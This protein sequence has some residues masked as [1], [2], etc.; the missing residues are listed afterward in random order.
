MEFIKVYKYQFSWFI[1]SMYFKIQIS[2][3]NICTVQICNIQ[4]SMLV[5][6]LN[7]KRIKQFKVELLKFYHFIYLPRSYLD[8]DYGTYAL[9]R[10]Q[11][12]SF[13][14]PKVRVFWN[15]LF[16]TSY[17][18]N[19]FLPKTYPSL[20]LQIEN[21][22]LYTNCIILVFKVTYYI[23]IIFGESWTVSTWIL[24]YISI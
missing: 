4:P 12:C 15:I 3:I 24:T 23:K 20:I 6:Y 14:T 16:T 10:F 21:D 7:F 2:T 13:W 18:N 19:W 11:E 1:I 17:K 9:N 8:F 22:L 5:T